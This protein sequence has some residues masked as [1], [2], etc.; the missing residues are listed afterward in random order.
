MLVCHFIFIAVM[1]SFMCSPL[2]ETTA[3]DMAQVERQEQP[4]RP[5]LPGSRSQGGVLDWQQRPKS[6][7]PPI[8]ARGRDESFFRNRSWKNGKTVRDHR[9]QL[10]LS[11]LSPGSQKQ[12]TALLSWVPNK[13]C[14]RLEN[15]TCLYPLLMKPWLS[16]RKSPLWEAQNIFW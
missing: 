5:L 6:L 8:E 4:A 7:T 3:S 11:N 9:S 13:T 1:S 12:N 10:I 15:M 14:H 16:D 2:I